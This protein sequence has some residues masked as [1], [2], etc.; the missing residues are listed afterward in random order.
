MD[1]FKLY[2]QD[3]LHD[4]ILTNKDSYLTGDF[5][6]DLMKCK[7][8]NNSQDFIELFMSATFL[9][10]IS[11]PTH[12][13]EQTSTLID[14][15]FCYV[16]PL[17]ESRIILSDISDH[18]PISMHVPIKCSKKGHY[19]RRKIT[20]DNLRRLQ[21]GLNEVDWSYIYDTEDIN[22]G[23]D[24]FMDVINSKMNEYIPLHK[25][26]NDYNKNS[27]TTMDIQISLEIN[28]SYK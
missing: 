28:K 20:D 7:N 12:V 22:L 11:K 21:Q 4:P 6:V 17:P 27:T 10:L 26:T 13:T 3:L 9:P 2:L 16:F 25:Y 1:D 24:Y 5:N 19:F 23:F 14:N 18:Y 8:C 15:L